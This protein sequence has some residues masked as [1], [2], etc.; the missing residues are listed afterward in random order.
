MRT[1]LYPPLV[2]DH[3]TISVKRGG[4][5]QLTLRAGAAHAGRVYQLAGSLTGTRPGFRLAGLD[6]ALNP[7]AYFVHTVKVGAP[8]IT[9]ASG[10][11]DASGEGRA[12][13]ALPPLPA[14]LV[15][16]KAHHAFVLLA[17]APIYTSN[18]ARV[19]LVP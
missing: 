11:L 6:V 12:A 9:P 1:T 15:G 18:A 16:V 3:G 8:P 13:L 19:E 17:P 10:R 14:S 4:A 2:A 7:D 5:Q